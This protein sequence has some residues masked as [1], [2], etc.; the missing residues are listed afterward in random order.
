MVTRTA[1][2]S[3]TFEAVLVRQCAPTLAGIKPGCIFCYPSLEISRQKV[4]LW[5]EQLAPL[6]VSVQMLLERPS[7]VIVY[8]Y[9]RKHLEQTLLDVDC[10][11]FLQDIGYTGADLD[12]LLAQL[13]YRLQT[14]TEFPHEIGV[15][16]GYPLRDVIGFIENHGQNFTCC[17][18]WKSY[19]DPTETQMCFSCYRSCIQSYMEM[20]EQGVPI[21]RLAVPA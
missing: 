9:R 6:G 12:G 21:Q 8:V 5:N 18:Y 11:H 20:F 2:S 14:Q 3:R 16:L 19:G 17:G 13:T 1:D 10:F 7:S 4:R 15:F